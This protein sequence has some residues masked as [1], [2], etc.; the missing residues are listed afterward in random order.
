MDWTTQFYQ[1]SINK[2]FSL[3]ELCVALQ[4]TRRMQTRP[5]KNGS[6]FLSCLM[7]LLV[8]QIWKEAWKKTP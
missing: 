4:Q 1:K 6:I 2:P 7:I 5:F 8:Q 3:K